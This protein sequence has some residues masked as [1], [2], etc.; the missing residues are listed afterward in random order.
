MAPPRNAAMPNSRAHRRPTPETGPRS[1]SASRARAALTF[2]SAG[3]CSLPPPDLPDGREWT[4][5][6]RARWLELWAT[7]QATQWDESA[8]G[9]VALLIVYESQL[10]AGDGT[11][12]LAAEHRHLS[13]ALGLTP[14]GLAALG[15]RIVED[16]DNPNG[17]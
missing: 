8:A 11:A 4:D 6:E 14:T 5:R 16:P 9:S 10:L 2:L 3:G 7:P 12:W 15:W 17:T 1:A 13:T